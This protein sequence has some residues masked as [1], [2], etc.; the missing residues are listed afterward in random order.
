[1]LLE[2][3]KPDPYD[4]NLGKDALIVR[5]GIVTTCAFDYKL[6]KPFQ[7]TYRRFS[8]EVEREYPKIIP[9]ITIIPRKTS[10]TIAIELENDI[11]WDFQESLRQLNKYKEMYSETKIIIPREYKRFAPLYIHEGFPVYLWSAKRKWKCRKCHSINLDE[12]RIPP[13]CKG[14]DERGQPCKNNSREEFDL[15]GLEDTKFKEYT[16]EL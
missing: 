10:K 6:E 9:D 11:K 13:K 14:K 2:L 7:P 5:D 4:G 12:S 15:V 3:F 16:S 8:G 1:L